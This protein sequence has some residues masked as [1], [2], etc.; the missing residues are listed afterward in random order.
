MQTEQIT[1]FLTTPEA[2]MF[3]SFQEFHST[4]FLLVNSGVFNIKGGS[5]VIHFDESGVIQNIERND[6]LFNSR[7][8]KLS[9]Y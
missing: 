9:T 7:V 8:K 1:I 3:K 2:E 5:A 6:T 4:F